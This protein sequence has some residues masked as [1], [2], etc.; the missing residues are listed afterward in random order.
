MITYFRIIEVFDHKSSYTLRHLLDGLVAEHARDDAVRAPVVGLRLPP[1]VGPV[2][3]V[4]Q[5]D[6]R[7]HQLLAVVPVVVLIDAQRLTQVGH[8]LL[9]LPHLRRPESRG[10]KT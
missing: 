1:S 3:R 4:S 9:L 8:R 6:D 2:V 10:F 5:S 7:R